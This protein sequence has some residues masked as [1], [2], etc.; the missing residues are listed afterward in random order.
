MSI[1]FFVNQIDFRNWLLIN[2]SNEKE[3]WIGFYNK[4]SN[5]KG[6]SYKDAIDEALCFGWID[7][8]RKSIDKI[9]YT[10]R[11]TPRTTKSIWSQVN[12]NRVTELLSQ[13][14][15]HPSGIKVFE[16]RD[17]KMEKL[18]SHE[19]EKF[20]LSSEYENMLKENLTAWNFYKNQSSSY[21]K[22]ATW[23]VIS[24]KQEVTRLK[25]L[26]ILIE[27]SEKSEKVPP[28]RRP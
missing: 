5:L 18:Y 3:I 4:K 20:E 28:L 15:M 12:I 14:K 21:K 17:T 27:C 13:G 8:I 1:Q 19:Q 25:R 9:S 6:I 24:A 10:N 11:F 23:W 22:Q 7:G 16:N 26:N 2:H